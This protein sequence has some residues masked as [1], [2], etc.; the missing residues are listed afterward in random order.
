MNSHQAF[1]IK[2]YC[3]SINSQPWDWTVIDLVSVERVNEPGARVTAAG[4]VSAVDWCEEK[5]HVPEGF[6]PRL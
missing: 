2:R 4:Q 3:R 5:H 1:S 6:E